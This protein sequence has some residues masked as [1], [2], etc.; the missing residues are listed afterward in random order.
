MQNTNTPSAPKSE[1]RRR[2]RTDLTAG[3]MLLA[4]VIGGNLLWQ[5]SDAGVVAAIAG[6]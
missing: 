3:G 2:V 6:R 1:P 4:I 5:A